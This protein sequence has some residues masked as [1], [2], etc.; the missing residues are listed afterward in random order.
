MSEWRKIWQQPERAVLRGGGTESSLACDVKVGS[1]TPDGVCE[2]SLS[3]C[4]GGCLCSEQGSAHPNQRRPLER[5]L[6]HTSD[7]LTSAHLRPKSRH[8]VWLPLKVM[9]NEQ[10]RMPD[11]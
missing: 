6:H 7:S 9:N 2:G 10:C 1:W 4:E 8:G 5:Y 11:I 3:P